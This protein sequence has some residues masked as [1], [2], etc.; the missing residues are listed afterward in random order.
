MAW[1]M[2]EPPRCQELQPWCTVIK[3]STTVAEVYATLAAHT[4]YFTLEQGG[5]PG[6]VLAR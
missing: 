2:L 5:I 6:K 1:E 4:I 3:V